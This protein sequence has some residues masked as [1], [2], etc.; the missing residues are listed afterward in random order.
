MV[1]GNPYEL[2]ADRLESIAK[3]IREIEAE[4]HKVLYDNNDDATTKN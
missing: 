2:L 3:Q 4:A 1:S